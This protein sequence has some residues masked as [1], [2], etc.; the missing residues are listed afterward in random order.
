[1]GISSSLSLSEITGYNVKYNKYKINHEI[2]RTLGLGLGGEGFLVS[3][4][5]FIFDFCGVPLVLLLPLESFV[6]SD[7]ALCLGVPL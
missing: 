1:M 6:P 3:P 7:G 2:Q 5:D 4:F